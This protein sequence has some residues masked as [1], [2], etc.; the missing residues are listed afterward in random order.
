M[1]DIRHSIQV[2]AAPDRVHSLVSSSHGFSL[3]WAADVTENAATKSVDLGFFNRSTIYRLQ[4]TDFLASPR[5]SAWLC[6]S[7]KEWVGTSLFFRIASVD[8]QTL[9]QFT[10]AGWQ[11]ETPYF[12]S[13]NTTWGALMYRLKAIAEGKPLGPLFSADGM[14][15]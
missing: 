12:I 15:Y 7:G 5:E 14:T 13:C 2:A 8:H 3:W 10:H 1:P 9:L 4:P 11:A 6:L